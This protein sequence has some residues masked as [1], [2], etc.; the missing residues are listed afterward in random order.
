[1]LKLHDHQTTSYD[2]NLRDLVYIIR[3]GFKIVERALQETKD[4][5]LIGLREVLMVEISNKIFA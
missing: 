2:L 5:T 3:S 1:M 4:Y